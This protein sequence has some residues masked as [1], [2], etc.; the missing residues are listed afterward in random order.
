M[1]DGARRGSLS[2]EDIDPPVLAVDQTTKSYGARRALDAVS[3]SVGA[4]EFVAL[5]GPNGAGKTTLFQLLSG[6]FVPDAGQ[7]R[8]EGGDLRTDI[9]Q[10]LAG[11]GIVF[12]QST[13]DL[14]LSVRAN[15]RFHARL[16]GLSPRRTR[17]RM[18]AELDRMGLRARAKEPARSLSGGN[19]RKVE[20]ARALLHDPRLLLMDEATAGL[21]PASR[22]ALL[23]T[24]H[25][26]CTARGIGVLWATHLVNEAERADRVVVLH[27]GH[28]LCEGTPDALV[29]ATGETDLG[30]S[31]LKLTSDDAPGAAVTSRAAP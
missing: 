10:V 25:Q 6:L 24:M 30:E 4:G 1:S 2:T 26:L 8:I 13:L 3:L 29:Q 9:P 17:E 16:H 20:L 21:D 31:F 27:H 5:L 12:Q 15:L 23:D 18:D 7:I 11:I 22:R 14:D 28:V 19:R